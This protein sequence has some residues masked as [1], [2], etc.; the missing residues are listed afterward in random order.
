MKL[1]NNL[2]NNNNNIEYSKA[3]SEQETMYKDLFGAEELKGVRI[4]FFCKGS[5]GETYL[6][7]LRNDT[8]RKLKQYD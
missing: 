6:D 5:A 1:Y 8:E 2:Y 4:R 3:V 7:F